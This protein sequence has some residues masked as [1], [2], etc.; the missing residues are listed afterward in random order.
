MLQSE[1]RLNR[2][3]LELSADSHSLKIASLQE[4][5]LQN[6]KTCLKIR[7]HLLQLLTKLNQKGEK[8]LDK[9]DESTVRNMNLLKSVCLQLA[10]VNTAN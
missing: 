6:E 1:E 3:T 8:R 5:T 10:E 9:D 2:S 4:E 7:S